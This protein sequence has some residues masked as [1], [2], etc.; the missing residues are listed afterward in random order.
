MCCLLNRALSQIARLVVSRSWLLN[1]LMCFALDNSECGPNV[2]VQHHVDTGWVHQWSNP[3]WEKVLTMLLLSYKLLVS[4]W[5][6]YIRGHCCVVFKDNASCTS[7]LNLKNP[8][9]CRAMVIQLWFCHCWRKSNHVAYSLSRNPASVLEFQSIESLPSSLTSE[10]DIRKLQKF[11]PISQGE[12]QAC[13]LGLG[14]PR[15]SFVSPQPCY[16]RCVAHFHSLGP[17]AN[18]EIMKEDLLKILQKGSCILFFILTTGDK[19][20]GLMF[21]S[22]L[23]CMCVKEGSRMSKTS[24]VATYSCLVTF[25]HG[26]CRCFAAISLTQ[27]ALVCLCFQGLFHKCG[28]RYWQQKI[29]QQRQSPGC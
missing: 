18:S 2:L 23:R 19:A 6:P 27:W 24:L 28:Q 10:S 7:L 3:H 16:S 12:K 8:L 15:Q 26:K 11:H 22:Y 1:I 21:V 4:F 25:P 13:K 5:Q 20:W 29:N 9:V 14:N 17:E